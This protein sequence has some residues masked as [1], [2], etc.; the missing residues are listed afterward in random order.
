MLCSIDK[1]GTKSGLDLEMTERISKAVSIPVITSG[2]CGLA[3]HF[4]D[5]Y[6]KGKAHA[7]SAGTYFCF[8]DQSFM[9]IRAHIN[10]AGIPIRLHT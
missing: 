7:V 1:D 9:Q 2:G 8:K 4:S 10:N 6:L 5:G 3:S